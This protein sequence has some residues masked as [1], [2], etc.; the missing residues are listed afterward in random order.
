MCYNA[1]EIHAK[2]GQTMTSVLIENVSPEFLPKFKALAKTA[3]AEFKRFVAD[4]KATKAEISAKA[5]DLKK[6]K[7]EKKAKVRAKTKEIATL[8]ELDEMPFMKNVQKWEQ[9]NP[10]EAKKAHQAVLKEMGIA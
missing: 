5:K 7:P 3:K 4:K 8:Q 6:A 10:K 9:E 2:K 1:C